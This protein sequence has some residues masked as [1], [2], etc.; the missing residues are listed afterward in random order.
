MLLLHVT[1]R[2]GL[3]FVSVFM[4]LCVCVKNQAEDFGVSLA[5]PTCLPPEERRSGAPQPRDLLRSGRPAVRKERDED[6]PHHPSGD[7]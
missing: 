4:C 1:Y 2:D 6:F 5:L 7:D 3:L